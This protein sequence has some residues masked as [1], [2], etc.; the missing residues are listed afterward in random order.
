M[1]KKKKPFRLALYFVER[2]QNPVARGNINHNHKK[3]R[4]FNLN[5]LILRLRR[6]E[7]KKKKTK[8]FFFFFFFPPIV[9]LCSASVSSLCAAFLRFLFFFFFF[10]FFPP[11]PLCWIACF[12]KY[13]LL[14][15]F[16][17]PHI[18]PAASVAF[19]HFKK[20][21]RHFVI[22]FLFQTSC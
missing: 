14:L 21:I 11:L 16:F 5:S 18:I 22:Y 13:H 19:A 6:Y 15:L 4:L 17:L 9:H 8:H 2:R 10:F 20:K 7:K 12:H 1:P 3:Y